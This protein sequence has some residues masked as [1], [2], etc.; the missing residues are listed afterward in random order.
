MNKARRKELTNL[1][2]LIEEI[3]TDM[4]E[5]KDRIDEW[6]CDIESVKDEEEEA[7]DNLPESLQGSARGEIM[8][9]AIADM[10]TAMDGADTVIGN[11]EESINGFDDI[12]EAIDTAINC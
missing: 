3:K 10:E 1:K 8:Q 7:Y 5:V 11:L 4:Q 12:V 2:D 9:E 6:K